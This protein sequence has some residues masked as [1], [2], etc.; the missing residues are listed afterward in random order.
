MH[1]AI[2]SSRGNGLN[3]GSRDRGERGLER[4][5]DR[6]AAGLRLPAEEATSVVLQS[7]SDPDRT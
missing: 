1:A 7:E 4:I 3:R 5:L 2:G 6:A